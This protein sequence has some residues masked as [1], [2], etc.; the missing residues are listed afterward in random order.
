MSCVS[1]LERPLA[2]VWQLLTVQV[3]PMSDSAAQPLDLVLVKVTVV[4]QVLEP[5]TNVDGTEDYYV[6]RKDAVSESEW[7]EP[8]EAA[9]R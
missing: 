9:L 4:R 1:L 5:R 6:I 2:V 8:R 7:F 3:E